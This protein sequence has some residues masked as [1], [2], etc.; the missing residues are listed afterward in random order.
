MTAIPRLSTEDK[1]EL[2]HLLNPVR[3][4]GELS[5]EELEAEIVR[6]LRRSLGLS[7]N[8]DL[9][10]GFRRRM[11]ELAPEFALVGPFDLRTDGSIAREL[12]TA[13]FG[14]VSDLAEMVKK[15]PSSD[16]AREDFAGFEMYLKT[17]NSEH[18]REW[19]HRAALAETLA[20]EGTPDATIVAN[21]EES[22]TSHTATARTLVK[23]LSASALAEATGR[24]LAL[25]AANP[26]LSTAAAPLGV[27]AAGAFL[28]TRRRKRREPE[29]SG[30]SQPRPRDDDRGERTRSRLSPMVQTIV[31]V[32]AFLLSQ[33]VGE[34]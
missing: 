25:G 16:E 30:E 13:V 29:V 3:S 17:K 34:V 33:S 6:N 1:R 12:V 4:S 5:D 20:R 8:I 32:C 11:I 22:S 24:S 27:V 28:Y 9:T 26:A 31:T 18:R 10:Q 21:A 19:L 2:L 14:Q 7:G 15:L 23:A